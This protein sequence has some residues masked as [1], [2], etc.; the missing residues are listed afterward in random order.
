MAEP[1][2]QQP[3]TNNSNNTDGHTLRMGLW[4]QKSIPLMQ[5]ILVKRHIFMSDV[6]FDFGDEH[7]PQDDVL[8]RFFSEPEFEQPFPVYE[9]EQEKILRYSNILSMAT[10]E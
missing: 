10:H 9:S 2:R 8:L 4:Q 1:V 3:A 7:M 6:I 5:F